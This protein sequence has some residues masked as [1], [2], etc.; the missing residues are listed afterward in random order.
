MQGESMFQLVLCWFF[1]FTRQCEPMVIS[2]PV[3]LHVC[4]REQIRIRSR[5]PL[6]LNAYCL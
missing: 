4:E 1:L 5:A 3:P 6:Y 2:R